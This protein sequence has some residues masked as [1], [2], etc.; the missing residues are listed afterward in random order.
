LRSDP[1]QSLSPSLEQSA[2]SESLLSPAAY[3]YV[4]LSVRR[5]TDPLFVARPDHL[6]SA[7]IALVKQL[8]KEV[9]IPVLVEDQFVPGRYGV[10]L[11]GPDVKENGSGAIRAADFHDR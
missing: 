4:F 5:L 7:T 3:R 10:G 1:R 2:S 11:Y 8:R 9:A 6:V